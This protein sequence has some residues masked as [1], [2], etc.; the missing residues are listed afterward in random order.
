MLI[1][2]LECQS[3]I[4]CSILRVLGD[5]VPIQQVGSMSV[6]QR[7]AARTR[8]GGSALADHTRSRKGNVQCQTIL[9]RSRKVL[10]IDTFVRLSLALTPEQQTFFGVRTFLSV[11]REVEGQME[12]RAAEQDQ[13]YWMSAI[14]KRRTRLQIIPRM[15][16]R[17]PSTMSTRGH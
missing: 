7:T 17:F 14:E 2:N 6:N 15:S 3:Q 8:A 10:D 9:E 5:R 1:S 16:F 12:L 13:T 11:K 4:I